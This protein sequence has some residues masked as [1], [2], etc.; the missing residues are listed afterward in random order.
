M[1]W[2]LVAWRTLLALLALSGLMAVSS[3]LPTSPVFLTLSVAPGLLVTVILVCSSFESDTPSSTSS[4]SST[5][6]SADA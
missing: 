1:D 2:S 6:G 4:G 3:L 5:E